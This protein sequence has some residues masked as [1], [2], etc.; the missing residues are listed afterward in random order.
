MDN[1]NIMT[2]ATKKYLEKKLI[3]AE[4]EMKKALLAIGI[5]AGPETNWHDNAAFE[6]ANVQFNVCYSNLNNLRKK[7]LNVEIIKPQ[8]ETNV[9]KI[10]NT[11]VVQFKDKKK[12]EKFTI[13][14]SDN[15][16]HQKKCISYTTL[17]SRAILG[18]KAGEN[19]VFKSPKGK[20]KIKI[21]T[22]LP[23]EFE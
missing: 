22:I 9:I 21:I 2:L 10:G 23:G 1:K 8:K 15:V 19:V 16:G 3:E 5:A 6:D 18:K 20:Q 14:G 17:F 7:L 12:S 13:L 4:K 11:V